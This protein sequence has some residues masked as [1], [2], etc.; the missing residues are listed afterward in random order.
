LNIL[1]ITSDIDPSKKL[2]WDRE[3]RQT[4]C[5]CKRADWSGRA[6]GIGRLGRGK[7]SPIILVKV[8]HRH[9][10]L[11]VHCRVGKVHRQAIDSRGFGFFRD[12]KTTFSLAKTEYKEVSWSELSE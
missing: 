11:Q 1:S 4:F 2:N 9:T 3:M 5:K 8:L 10:D 6:A 7:L 12:K